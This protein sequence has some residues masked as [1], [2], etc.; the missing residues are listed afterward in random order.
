MVWLQGLTC[1][2]VVT[3]TPSMALLAAVLLGPGLLALLFDREPGRPMARSVL[4]CGL[5]ACIQ[6]LHTLWSDQTLDAALGLL[7]D[8]QTLGTAWSAA[9][10]GW[11]MAELVPVGARLV[12]ETLAH[13][14]VA[15]LRAERTRLAETWGF[16]RAEQE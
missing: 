8:L 2:A 10:A 9:A 3:L 1:G 11:L 7:G 14:R 12:L 6:P 4:L 15:R 5:A 13:A 16:E